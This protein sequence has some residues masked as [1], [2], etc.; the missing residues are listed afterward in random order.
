MQREVIFCTELHSGFSPGE[1]EIFYRLVPNDL[2]QPGPERCFRVKAP[3]GLIGSHKGFLDSVFSGVCV[4]RNQV[5]GSESNLL[6]LSN[7]FSIG[8]NIT[9]Y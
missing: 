7:Q 9:F 8:A 6:V 5:S 4:F 3:H 2:Q 1:P